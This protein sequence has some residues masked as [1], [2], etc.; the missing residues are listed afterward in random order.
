MHSTLVRL[1]EKAFDIF[2]CAISRC[3]LVIV[4]NVVASIIERRVEE[5]IEPNGI[6]TETLHI[7][8][9]ADDALQV[10]YAIAI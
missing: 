6:N 2:I 1:F 7:I 8:Q 5:W 9:L 10:A 3:N 4:A